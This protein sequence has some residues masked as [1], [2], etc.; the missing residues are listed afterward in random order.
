MGNF[1][2]RNATWCHR[3][4]RIGDNN[5]DGLRRNGHGLFGGGL[6]DLIVG[7]QKIVTAH[8]RLAGKT[9]RYD[10][11]VGTGCR[12]VIVRAGDGDVVAFYRTGLK[13]VEAF[14]L[15][16]AFSDVHEN[17]IAQFLLRRPNG[18]IGAHITGANHCNLISQFRFGP[19]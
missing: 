19:F 8:T 4:Q 11:H 7:Q 1:E 16:N 2:T 6:N 9:G 10:H 5:N 13:Q 17:D 15:R 14:T 3:I 12:R 18:T